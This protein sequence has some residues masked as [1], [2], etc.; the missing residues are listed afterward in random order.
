M[1]Q[2]LNNDKFEIVIANILSNPLRILAPALAKLTNNTL[3]LSGI[4]DTQSEEL[5]DIYKPWFKVSVIDT[6][7]G[8]ALLQCE[9]R[10]DC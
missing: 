8:W 10:H 4:L 9:R 6:L 7:D 1:P 3:V 2:D 5:I